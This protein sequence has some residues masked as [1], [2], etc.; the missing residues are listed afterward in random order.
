MVNDDINKLRKE[1]A[2]LEK[3]LQEKEE[4][5]QLRKRK[6]EL[7]EEGTVKAKIKDKLKKLH[8]HL[9]EKGKQ[10]REEKTDEGLFKKPQ[11]GTGFGTKKELYDNDFKSP[12]TESIIKKK[13]KR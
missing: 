5:E 10:Y 11:F 7:E 12:I 2:D 8:S 9:Q 3:K 4:I 1:V 6:K 13:T